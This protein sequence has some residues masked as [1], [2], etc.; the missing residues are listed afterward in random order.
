MAVGFSELPKYGIIRIIVQEDEEEPVIYYL[1]VTG[2]GEEQSP[3]ALTFDANGG[4]VNGQS[5]VTLTYDEGMAGVA[6][7]VPV[8]D[9][10]TFLGWYAGQKKLFRLYGRYE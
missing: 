10:Y 4:T 5:E 6:L 3:V 2:D 9:N 1:N 8:R 7:P